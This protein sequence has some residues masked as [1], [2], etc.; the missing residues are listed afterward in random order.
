MRDDRQDRLVKAVD[1]AFA[2]EDQPKDWTDPLR[3]R[4]LQVLAKAL[5]I[6][7]FDPPDSLTERAKSLFT[8]RTK[9]R[10][11]LRLLN[12]PFEGAGARLADG[13]VVQ[14]LFE[15]DGTR[16]RVM[17][18]RKAGRIETRGQIEGEGWT[19]TCSTAT[20]D[21]GTEGRFVHAVMADPDTE[22][23]FES[24]DVRFTVPS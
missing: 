4:Q 16:L 20:V 11:A 18:L 10:P 21:C 14:A 23:T 3:F 1:A 22:M 8:A 5:S 12:S 2:G 9:R 17:Y 19:V 15:A 13:Q 7:H 24:A 6:D